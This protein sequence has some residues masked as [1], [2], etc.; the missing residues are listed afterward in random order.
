MVMLGT[1]FISGNEDL[2]VAV[3]TTPFTR[4]LLLW[5]PDLFYGRS[6]EAQKIEHYSCL[7]GVNEEYLTDPWRMDLLGLRPRRMQTSSTSLGKVASDVQIH[8]A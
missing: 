6:F 5:D 8:C 1:K 7:L 4:P 3:V 2:I